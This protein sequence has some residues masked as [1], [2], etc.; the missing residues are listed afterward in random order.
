MLKFITIISLLF[1]CVANSQSGYNLKISAKT[2]LS[3]SKYSDYSGSNI[4]FMMGDRVYCQI[5][6]YISSVMV[7][8]IVEITLNNRDL[9]YKVENSGPANGKRFWFR[10]E[11]T[12]MDI[13]LNATITIQFRDSRRLSSMGHN[14]SAIYRVVFFNPYGFPLF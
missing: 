9:E 4:M 8:E 5:I 6:P 1:V 3:C 13:N 11:T 10:A 2:K 14:T 12:G 7:Y